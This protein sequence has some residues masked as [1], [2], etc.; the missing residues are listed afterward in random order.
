MLCDTATKARTP[1]AV[2]RTHPRTERRTNSCRWCATAASDMSDTAEPQYCISS[3]RSR[4]QPSASTS[5]AK[6]VSAQ[7][8]ESTNDSSPLAVAAMVIMALS[9]RNVQSARHKCRRAE[10]GRKFQKENPWSVM[11]VQRVRSSDSIRSAAN[12]AMW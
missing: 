1:G 12:M 9:V 5:T 7:Q 8:N 11:V 4:G 10:K 3:T 6:S 2:T